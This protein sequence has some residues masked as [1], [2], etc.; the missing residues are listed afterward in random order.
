MVQFSVFVLTIFL[1]LL[2]AEM[3]IQH[4]PESDMQSQVAADIS[5]FQHHEHSLAVIE[6]E[7][8]QS[9]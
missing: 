1:G 5:S 7:V 2:S 9:N 4:S 6:A 3:S 8:S